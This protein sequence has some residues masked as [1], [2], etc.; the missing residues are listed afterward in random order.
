MHF[1]TKYLEALAQ[2]LANIFLD[3]QIKG[4]KGHE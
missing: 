3:F 1:S 2:A 4:K